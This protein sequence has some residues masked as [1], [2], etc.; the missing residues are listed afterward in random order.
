MA[1]SIRR[2]RR[3]PIFGSVMRSSPCRSVARARLVSH[4]RR[5]AHRAREPSESALDEMEAR[6]ASSATRNLLAGDQ[7]DGAFDRDPH[8]GRVDRRQVDAD[9]Q[10]LVGF[11]HVDRRRALAGH[12]G[13]ATQLAEYAADLVGKLTKLRRQHEVG[14]SGAHTA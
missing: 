10:R 12:R 2:P 7:H 13:A 5:E 4:G 1:I 14:D 6:I 3:S 8:I 9:L 11:V